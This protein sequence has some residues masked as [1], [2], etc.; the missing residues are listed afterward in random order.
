MATTKM[1]KSRMISAIDDSII[2]LQFVPMFLLLGGSDI[3]D[4][5]VHVHSLA[6]SEQCELYRLTTP[7][8]SS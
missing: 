6:I 4:R 5:Y 7:T 2:A 8:C 1:S 3:I